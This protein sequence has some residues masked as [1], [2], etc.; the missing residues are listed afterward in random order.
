M[1]LDPRL[2]DPLLLALAAQRVC[3]RQA[4]PLPCP[5]RQVTL[6][7]VYVN[8]LDGSVL[9]GEEYV[10]AVPVAQLSRSWWSEY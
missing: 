10:Y 4:Q 6:R 7:V 2:A 9:P 8:D 5:M 1:A 3:R